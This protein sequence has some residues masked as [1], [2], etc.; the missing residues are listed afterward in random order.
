LQAETLKQPLKPAAPQLQKARGA[1]DL[2]A[3]ALQLLAVDVVITATPRAVHHPEF[4]CR[5]F[6]LRR[7]SAVPRRG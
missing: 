4:H 2:A 3:G 1:C 5:A 7:I 6:D